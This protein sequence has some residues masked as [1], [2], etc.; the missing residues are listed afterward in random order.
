MELKHD[1]YDIDNKK[2]EASI[3]LYHRAYLA[4]SD[5]FNMLSGPW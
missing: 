2:T 4:S 5:G 1:F 3:L